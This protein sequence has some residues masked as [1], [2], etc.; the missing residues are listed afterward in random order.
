[1]RPRHPAGPRR[2]ARPATIVQDADVP[3]VP[4]GCV[5]RLRLPP[6]SGPST[7]GEVSGILRASSRS[8]FSL[9]A[10]VAELADA[11]ASGAC[12]RK[13]VEVQILSS[14]PIFRTPCVARNPG[15]NEPQY[16][17]GLGGRNLALVNHRILKQ[18]RASG[19]D[20]GPLRRVTVRGT[21]WSRTSSSGRR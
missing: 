20:L 13:V 10:E 5:C 21:I 16:V 4:A 15:L 8:V 7:R 1:M 19:L 18:L 9:R 11:Q 3:P 2:R 17:G 12:G 6:A 14:A